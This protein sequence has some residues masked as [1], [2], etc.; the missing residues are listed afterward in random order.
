MQLEQA[1]KDIAPRLRGLR[2]A[3][4]MSVADLAGKTGVSAA[5]IETYEAGETE[6]PVGFLMKVAQIGR[7]HV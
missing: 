7:A 2:D 3:L 1:Y 6:I 4:D 5:L